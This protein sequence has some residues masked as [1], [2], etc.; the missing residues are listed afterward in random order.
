MKAV[1][2]AVLQIASPL[3]VVMGYILTTTIKQSMKWTVSYVIQSLLFGVFA[4]V[5][6][7]IPLDYFSISL[8]CSNPPDHD[9]VGSKSVAKSTEKIQTENNSDKYSNEK[10]AREIKSNDKDK[11]SDVT[12]VF[13]NIIEDDNKA[14]VFWQSLWVLLKVKVII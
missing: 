12:S 2:M 11:E 14:R 9:K 10:S 3:G 6:I 7:F 4:I 1:M 13:E 5:L 8:H